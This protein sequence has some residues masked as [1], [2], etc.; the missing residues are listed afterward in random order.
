MKKE[1]DGSPSAIKQSPKS[2]PSRW[3]THKSQRAKSKNAHQNAVHSVNL[4]I[5]YG[6]LNGI[7]ANEKNCEPEDFSEKPPEIVRAQDPDHGIEVLIFDTEDNGVGGSERGNEW[8]KER[9]E[10]REIQQTKTPRA[11]VISESE[12]VV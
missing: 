12:A 11:S 6:G 10:S 8:K 4:K 2:T 9:K 1:S 5:H 7:N 3:R